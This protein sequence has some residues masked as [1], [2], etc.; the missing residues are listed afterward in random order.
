MKNEPV[1]FRLFV[2]LS[3]VCAIKILYQTESLSLH[4]YEIGPNLVFSARSRDYCISFCT[5]RLLHEP[6]NSE[7]H[8]NLSAAYIHLER[9]IEAEEHAVFAIQLRPNF[10][11]VS[12]LE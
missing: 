3:N 9:Y 1:C 4:H 7:L 11:K 2:N 6:N 10:Y 8:T 12:Y 5:A